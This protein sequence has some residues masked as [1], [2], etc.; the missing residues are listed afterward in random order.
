MHPGRGQCGP[1]PAPLSTR[2]RPPPHAELLHPGLV[3][4]WKPT[5]LYRSDRQ[6]PGFVVP[7]ATGGGDTR[8]EA[9]LLVASLA[10]AA[11]PPGVASLAL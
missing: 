1:C 11:H 4:A 7:A 10:R 5:S 2:P 8:L 9:A 3:A 6:G